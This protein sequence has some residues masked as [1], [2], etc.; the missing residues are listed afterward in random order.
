MKKKL[1]WLLTLVVA[2]A[3]MFS[4]V[5]CGSSSI[6]GTYKFYSLKTEENGV[7]IELKAGESFMGVITLSKDFMAIELKEDGTAI[8]SEQGMTITGTW[9][10]NEEDIEKIDITF[11]G[12]TQ[13]TE[14]D[15]KE[16]RI[17]MNGMQFTLRK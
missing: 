7:M 9:K 4:L 13:T 2:V 11:E 3:A 12:D 14:C 10:V 15:G 6:E 1:V 8:A 17:M 16:I 5:A